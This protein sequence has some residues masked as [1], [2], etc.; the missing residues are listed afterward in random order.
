M[1][2]LRNQGIWQDYPGKAVSWGKTAS[3]WTKCPCE[4]RRRASF[5]LIELLVV[6]AI[7]AILAALLLPSLQKA[8]IA[9]ERAICISRLKQL[10]LFY[11][12]YQNAFSYIPPN[13]QWM[14]RDGLTIPHTWYS[15][16]GR[17]EGY[18]LR[19]S[20]RDPDYSLYIP[21][22]RPPLGTIPIFMC[23]KGIMD[24]QRKGDFNYAEQFFYNVG[25]Y[26]SPISKYTKGIDLKR[27]SEKILL[28]EYT[29]CSNG[30]LA[31][32]GSTPYAAIISYSDDPRQANDF[33]NGRHNRTDNALFL[34]GHVTT[35]AVDTLIL[36]YQKSKNNLPSMFNLK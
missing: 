35:Y 1:K 28:T 11:D 2:T 13:F 12:N 24:L 22:S 9:G 31:G 10:H 33:V 17:N 18:V 23:P 25:G 21:P 36:E 7:I 16:L 14:T 8:K 3:A 15:L 26:G 30:Q 6:I 4:K 5:T 20:S 34:D 19:Q 32:A 29:G 27:Y